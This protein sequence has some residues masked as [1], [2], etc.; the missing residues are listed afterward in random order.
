MLTCLG[1]A[2]ERKMNISFHNYSVADLDAMIQEITTLFPYCGD[3][4]GHLRSHSIRVQRQL[5]RDSLWRIDPSGIRSHCRNVLHRWQYSVPSPNTL[6]HID[7]H[8]KL[9]WWHLVIHGGIDGFSQ[10]IMFLKVSP[11]NKA[12][13]VLLSKVLNSLVYLVES[14]WTWVG[15]M[16]WLLRT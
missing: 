6:W 4:T 1:V 5:V 2:V 12:E 13:T 11:N 3:V 8:H 14:G 10:L 9:I 7:G 15:R 16:Y